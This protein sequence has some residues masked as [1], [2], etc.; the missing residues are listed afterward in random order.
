MLPAE[1]LILFLYCSPTAELEAMGRDEPPSDS[2]R[3]N[4][5]S[6]SVKRGRTT[7]LPRRVAMY[8]PETQLDT[9]R[10]VPA[11]DASVAVDTIASMTSCTESSASFAKPAV[12]PILMAIHAFPGR[13]P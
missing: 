12:T 6:I 9:I 7:S 8:R 4:E 2:G 1:F 5:M 3:S 10:A 11:V 13:S